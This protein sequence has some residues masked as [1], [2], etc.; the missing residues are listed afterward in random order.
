MTGV[1]TCA[2]PIYVP[3]IQEIRK[4]I[5]MPFCKILEKMMERDPQKRFQN[6]NDILRTLESLERRGSLS[7]SNPEKSN[8]K[9]R[10][11]GRAITQILSSSLLPGEENLGKYLHGYFSLS[12]FN[13]CSQE[14]C[15]KK[16]SID[17]IS[18]K[19]AVIFKEQVWC[20]ECLWKNFNE[21]MA[22]SKVSKL[23]TV[24]FGDLWMSIRSVE[25]F[26][27]EEPIRILYV[28]PLKRPKAGWENMLKRI[29]RG[30]SLVNKIKFSGL[31][32]TG[33]YTE[34]KDLGLAYV[35][36]EYIPG[37]S[38]DK[39]LEYIQKKGNSFSLQESVVL[40]RKLCQS[41]EVLHKSNIVHRNV[42]PRSINL[43]LTGGV[44]LGNFTMAKSFQNQIA[45]DK[46]ATGF[47]EYCDEY[48]LSENEDTQTKD[49]TGVSRCALGTIDY[50]S[51]EQTISASTVDNRSD[52]WSLGVISFE[53]LEGKKPFSGNN[54]LG[55]IQSIREGAVPV[56]TKKIP[57]PLQNIVYKC[58]Q[59][60]I[61][62]RFQNINEIIK[63]LDL[64][65]M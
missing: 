26:L 46:E 17:Q 28:F 50:M 48:W 61:Q 52:I 62:N 30:F 4:D 59:K 5:P 32:R 29:D 18:S 35:P 47:K 6:G 16:W 8:I 1:Q 54:A 58:L 44:R 64:I 36:L 49:I 15:N 9:L 38:L 55:I 23:E 45:T 14:S 56:F 43:S 20:A 31:I 13:K 57:V 12:E 51:P 53:I 19:E 40:I 39:L 42:T 41:L 60:N 65:K 3:Q 33:H 37:T 34:C 7:I 21:S 2:L 22:N 10:D 27:P 25:R 24:S 11:K 63:S